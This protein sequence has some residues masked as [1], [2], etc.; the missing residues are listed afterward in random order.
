MCSAKRALYGAKPMAVSEKH[1]PGV[2]AHI[3]QLGALLTRIARDFAPATLASS[4]SIEDMV[5][6]DAI[7]RN[8]IA[9]SVFALDTGRLHADTL[10][11]V[12]AIH[13]KYGRAVEV[14]RPDADAVRNYVHAHGS[15]AFYKSIELRKHCCEIR[16]VEPLRRALAGKRA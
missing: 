1:Y 6:V 14:Y 2:P 8:N 10:A 13:A 7:L 16:K 15:D 3:E 12:E 5:L 11:V 4:F 9:I